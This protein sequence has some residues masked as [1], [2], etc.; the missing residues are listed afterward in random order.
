M[1]TDPSA[2]IAG[3]YR[4]RHLIWSMARRDVLGRY[5]GS[6]LGVLWTVAT[7]L[8]L[9]LVYAFVFGS[10][11]Q[12]KWGISGSVNSVFVANLFLGLTIYGFFAEVFNKAPMLVVGNTNYVKK[13]VFP[14]DVLPWVTV[15]ASLFQMAVSLALLL[16]FSMV[17]DVPLHWTV[18]LLPV[19]LLP[20]ILVMMGFAWLLA[21]LGVFI[22]DLSQV[23]TLIATAAM[24]L[25]PVFFPLSAVPK[26]YA[27]LFYLNPL[28]WVLESG[29]GLV[30]HGVLPGVTAVSIYLTVS[31]LLYF[32]GYWVFSRLRHGFADVL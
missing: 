24:F 20:F 23:T 16:V 2:A 12:S 30:F 29:R 1:K 14:L 21:A 9:L 13:V 5:Q 11:F 32:L 22:R 6:L 10:V 18:V 28:T 26:A 3:I 15:A 17:A 25:S 19:L 8:I 31:L 4:H 27:S 7:P